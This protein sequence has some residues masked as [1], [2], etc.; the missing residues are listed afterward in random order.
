M[1]NELQLAVAHKSRLNT[2]GIGK[3][4]TTSVNKKL[5]KTVEDL[6]VQQQG[7]PKTTVELSE[8][9]SLQ[10][11]HADAA[12]LTQADGGHKETQGWTTVKNTS[13]NGMDID[14]DQQNSK[15]TQEKRSKRNINGYR[16]RAHT[17]ITKC[18]KQFYPTPCQTTPSS[19]GSKET[20]Y[21]TTTEQIKLRGAAAIKTVTEVVTP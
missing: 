13:K 10:K 9:K 14:D 20:G 4:K 11:P 19:K 21:L 16:N 8:E 6:A 17:E 15:N 7:F 1:A 18:R 5:S 3:A 2:R 12:A